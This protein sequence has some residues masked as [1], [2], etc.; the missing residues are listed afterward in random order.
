M[1]A[2]IMRFMASHHIPYEVVEHAHAATSLQNAKAAHIDPHRIAK[3][4]LLEGDECMLAAV[5]PADRRV[6]LGRL[7]ADVGKQLHLAGEN[8]AGRLFRDCEPGAIPALTLAYGVEMVWDDS[9]L[10]SDDL[11][12]EFGDHRQLVHVRTADLRPILENMPHG[13]F[14]KRMV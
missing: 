10:E 9:L 2:T 6:H 14:S 5:V 1:S 8:D 13:S 4:V 12:F 7:T 3:A 11:Y